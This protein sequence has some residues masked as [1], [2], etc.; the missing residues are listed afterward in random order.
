M[1]NGAGPTWGTRL[2]AA[3]L[4]GGGFENFTND[5]LHG[6]TGGGGSWNARA[7]VGTRQYVGL[8]AAYVGTAHS[9]N[10]LGLSNANL[11]SNGL[12]G[13]FRLN[14]PM[15]QGESLF[16]PFGFVGLGWQHYSVTNSN[17]NMSDIADKDDVMT[18]PV[19]GGFEYAYRMF[20]A[21]ARF[22]YR[23]T[24]YNDLMRTSGGKLNNWGVGGQVG[25]A[26]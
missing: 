23:E 15:V 4:I 11:V 13:A 9:I 2:G 8:E 1:D 5:N 19:G 20:I 6:M 7:V 18:L 26:F 21:D 10:T 25:V 12:E 24:Y 3:V 17:I 22:T 14:V 16:V